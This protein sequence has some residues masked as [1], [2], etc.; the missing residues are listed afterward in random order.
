[1]GSENQRALNF[2]PGRDGAVWELVERQHGVIAR[3]QLLSWGYSER[4]IDHRLATGRL[5]RL[6]Q[7]VYAV[8]RPTVGPYGRWMA[9]VLAC[10]TKAALSH[11]SAAA[12][13]RIGFEERDVVEVSVTCPHQRR[14]PGLRIYR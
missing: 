4:A 10:G 3:R 14:R 11:S 5:H 8:G 13:W 12:L 7:G 6:H 1:M 9:A 2:Q